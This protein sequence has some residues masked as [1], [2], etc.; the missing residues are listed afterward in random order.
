M[1]LHKS[2]IKVADYFTILPTKVVLLDKLHQAI[3][4]ARNRLAVSDGENFDGR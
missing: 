4:I 3:S 2:K 1:Q